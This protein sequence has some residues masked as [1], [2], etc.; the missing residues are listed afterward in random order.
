MIEALGQA[1]L[2]RDRQTHA[3]AERVCAYASALSRALGVEDKKTLDAID[4]AA[5]LHD[6]GKLGIPDRL[7]DKPGPLTAYEYELVKQH[8]VM[9]SNLLTAARLPH[10]LCRIVRHHH[11][12]WDGAGYPDGLQGEAIPIGARLLAVVDCYDALTSER[13]YRSALSHAAAVQL[14]ADSRATSFDPAITDVF[15]AAI[16]V[17]RQQLFSRPGKAAVV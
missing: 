17:W 12:R 1:L 10:V 6:V 13:P 15:V 8:A 3:H 11:E 5:L 16:D 14:I 2:A 7:L 9:G 4:G